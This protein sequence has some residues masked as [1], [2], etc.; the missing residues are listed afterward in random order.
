MNKKE[1]Y[2]I[3]KTLKIANRSKMNKHDLLNAIQNK[4]SEISIDILCFFSKSKD[5]EPGKGANEQVTDTSMYSELSTKTN[6]RRV[7]SNFHLCPFQ[8]KGYTYNTIEHV[9]QAEKIALI[10]KEKAKWFTLES[11]HPIGQGDGVVAQKNR[12]LVRLN[13][14]LLAKWGTIKHQI[15]KEAAIEKFKVCQEACDILKLTRKAQL[16]HIVMRGKPIRFIHLED[17]RASL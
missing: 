4:N 12:K 16:W 15:M 9:F 3:A 14:E 2:D 7:L 8:Y 1:L 6:W 13:E 11:G 17:I 5:V 10:D